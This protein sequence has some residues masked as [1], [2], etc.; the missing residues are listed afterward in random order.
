MSML[1]ESLVATLDLVVLTMEPPSSYKFGAVRKMESIWPITYLD[2]HRY[3]LLS[4]LLRFGSQFGSP[5]K[6]M[7]R[8][9]YSEVQKVRKAFQG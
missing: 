1:D 7:D 9:T 6:R 3:R 4:K 8:R 2:T 5:F